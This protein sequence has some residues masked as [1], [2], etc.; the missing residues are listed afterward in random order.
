M[1]GAWV[2][3]AAVAATLPCDDRAL[4]EPDYV[5]DC[6]SWA[7]PGGGLPGQPLFYH[8]LPCSGAAP[9]KTAPAATPNT[10]HPDHTVCRYCRDHMEAR[11]EYLKRGWRRIHNLPPQDEQVENSKWYGFLTRMCRTCEIAEQINIRIRSGAMGPAGFPLIPTHPPLAQR[12]QMVNYPTNT[13][14]C[15]HRVVGDPYCWTHQMRKWHRELEL[16]KRTRARNLSFLQHIKLDN[17]PGSAT[18]GSLCTASADTIGQRGV[19]QVHRAC[20]CGADPVPTVAGAQVFMC[21]VCEGIM[22]VTPIGLAGMAAVPVGPAGPPAAYLQHHASPGL[23]LALG[24][25][26]LPNLI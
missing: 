25:P 5:N 9:A 19:D 21:L 23:P 15:W 14:K 7:N 18:R 13:C 12:L 11:H 24:R 20:R 3:P 17:T 6:S 26:Q 1:A 4:H 8:Q 16:M 10:P 22:E 2:A